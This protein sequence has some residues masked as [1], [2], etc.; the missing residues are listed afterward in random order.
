MNRRLSYVKCFEFPAEVLRE[1]FGDSLLIFL[2]YPSDHLQNL[3]LVF[4]IKCPFF[5]YIFF[6][7]FFFQLILISFLFIYFFK[8][9]LILFFSDFF[10]FV[11]LYSDLK[12]ETKTNGIKPN[13]SLLFG[14]RLWSPITS[15]K[16]FSV[17]NWQL[18]R[19]YVPFDYFAYFSPF[20]F[21]D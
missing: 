18:R 14:L 5:F 19:W 2:F 16:E 20:R 17:I 3:I 13:K 7:F 1:Y 21:D 15:I 6:V 4:I 8:F 9:F 11:L 10:S 12:P